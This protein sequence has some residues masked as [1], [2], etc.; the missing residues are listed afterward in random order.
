M[1]YKKMSL[2]KYQTKKN[3]TPKM[4][5]KLLN[6]WQLSHQHSR[7]PKITLFKLASP[8]NNYDQL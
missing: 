3:Y 1:F 4:V 2:N 5:E 8:C 7:N 6:G